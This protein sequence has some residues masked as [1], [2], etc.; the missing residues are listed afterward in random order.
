MLPIRLLQYIINMTSGMDQLHM[1]MTCKRYRLKLFITKPHDI[2]IHNMKPI[3]NMI[4]MI[5]PDNYDITVIKIGKRIWFDV[6]Q[7]N[8]KLDNFHY[9]DGNINYG[10]NSNY[11]LREDSMIYDIEDDIVN[12]NQISIHMLGEL[13][14]GNFK[15]CKDRLENLTQLIN[16]DGIII[17]AITLRREDHFRRWIIKDVL[18]NIRSK[19]SYHLN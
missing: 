13:K 1:K 2:V 9:G 17:L 11:I 7:I 19:G 14:L 3:T 12:D 15:S 8:C 18:Y 5:I 4:D 10:D 6:D 16:I